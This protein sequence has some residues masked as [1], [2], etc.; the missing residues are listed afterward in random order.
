M[1]CRARSTAVPVPCPPTFV[2]RA[3]P[4]A[5]KT[6]PCH[7]VPVPVHVLTKIVSFRAMTLPVPVPCH[8]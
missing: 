4:H 7:A 5:P 8:I 6:V 1:S 2:P 3:S